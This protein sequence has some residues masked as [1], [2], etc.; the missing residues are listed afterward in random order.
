MSTESY[1]DLTAWQKSIA[2]TLQIYRLTG[3]FPQDERFGLVTQMRRAA[4]S[5]PSNI[6][7]GQGRNTTGEFIQ[8]LSRAEGPLAELGTQLFLAI[9]LGFLAS[10]ESSELFEQIVETR[11]MQ[12][13]LKR[14]LNDKR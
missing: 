11:S 13:T 6:A 3:N 10:S 2:L 7:E 8:L 4:V 12:Q 5:V 14:Q 1:R 9:E